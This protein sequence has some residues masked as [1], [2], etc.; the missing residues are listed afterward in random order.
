MK[1]DVQGIVVSKYGGG[2]SGCSGIFGAG[3]LWARRHATG[4]GMLQA[5]VARDMAR[6]GKPTPKDIDRSVVKLHEV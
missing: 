4:F 2:A 3:S 1:R 6:T 5:E